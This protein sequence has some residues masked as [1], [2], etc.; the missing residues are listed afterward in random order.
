MPVIFQQVIDEM[1]DGLSQ[2]G[3]IL[4]DLIVTGENDEQHVF[5]TFV[6]H[7]KFEDCGATRKFNNSK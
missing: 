5:R 3:G 7:K 2:S 1:L 4:D 6:R